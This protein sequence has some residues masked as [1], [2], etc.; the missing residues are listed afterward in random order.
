MEP[1]AFPDSELED[2]GLMVRADERAGLEVRDMESLR[3]H[4][5]ITLRHWARRLEERWD[6]ARRSGIL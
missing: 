2:I 1:F 5:E 3:E 6:E 4:Y